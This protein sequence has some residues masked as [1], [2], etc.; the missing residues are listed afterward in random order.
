[1]IF[2][3]QRKKLLASLAELDEKDALVSRWPDREAATGK[4]A[5]D[6]FKRT[7]VQHTAYSRWVRGIW[8]PSKRNVKKVE[9]IFERAG[10]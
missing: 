3:T 5:R 9:K 7:T 6:I 8:E 10:V 4:S 2:K 1:M